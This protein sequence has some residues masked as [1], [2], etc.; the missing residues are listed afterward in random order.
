M[1]AYGT[2]QTLAGSGEPRPKSPIGYTQRLCG[3]E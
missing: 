1:S 3:I 2:K